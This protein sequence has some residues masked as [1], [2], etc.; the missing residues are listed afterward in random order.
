MA[1]IRRRANGSWNAQIRLRGCTPE[2]ITG[3]TKGEVRQLAAER[4]R[5]LRAG[6][7]AADTRTTFAELLDTYLRSDAHLSRKTAPQAEAVLEG[8]RRRFGSVRIA[9][10]SAPMI[11]DARDELLRGGLKNDSVRRRMNDLSAFFKWAVRERKA[12]RVNPCS[13]VRKPT[14]G[15]GRTRYLDPLKERERLFDACRRQTRTPALYPMVVLATYTGMRRGELLALKWTD[16]DLDRGRL[17]VRTSKNGDS[18]IVPVKGPAL[19]ALKQWLATREERKAGNVERVFPSR[20]FPQEAWVRAKEE[21]G[22]IDFRFHDLRH[23]MGSLLTQSGADIAG[24]AQILGHRTLKMARRYSHHS[25]ESQD[26]IAERM[27]AMFG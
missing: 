25:L 23:T 15:Q 5:E 20:F 4:E 22:L 9:K 11:A 13:D 17:I 12:I 8:W 18:R 2:S 19:E 7:A 21:A 6:E 27:V 26:G 16:I 24:V 1:T 3:A 10:I 14:E